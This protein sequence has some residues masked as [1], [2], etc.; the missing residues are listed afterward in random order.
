MADI[1]C[2]LVIK[3]PRKRVFDAVSTPAGLD[4]WWTKSSNGVPR[5][6]APY[7]LDFGPDHQWA[8][9][10]TKC[11]PPSAFELEMTDAHPDWLRTRV[12]FELRPLPE[13]VTRLL[14]HHT[15]WPAANDHWRVSCSCWAAYL[16]LLRRHLE[17]G[18]LVPYEARLDA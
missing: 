10:V 11:T 5:E 9:T 14:F 3:V 8:A 13:T 1:Q 15:G 17:H 4:T 7:T 12:G 18:E 2:E 6:G 16:R